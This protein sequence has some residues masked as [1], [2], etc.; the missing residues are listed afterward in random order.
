MIDDDTGPII[1]DSPLARL[2][3]ARWRCECGIADADAYL[4][5]PWLEPFAAAYQNRKLWYL[6]NRDAVD[7]AI[8]ALPKEDRQ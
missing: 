8:A 1:D 5:A 4:H 6:T 7:R 2:L 3:A